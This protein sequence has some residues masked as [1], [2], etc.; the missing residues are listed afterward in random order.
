MQFCHRKGVITSLIINTKPEANCDAMAKKLQ[1]VIQWTKKNISQYN[2]KPNQN[3]ITGHSSRRTSCLAVMNP[4]YGTDPKSI[5]GIILN[6][7]AGLD[8]KLFRR[9]PTKPKMII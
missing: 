9:N 4:K 1:S 3:F 2:V 8:E 6:D 7:A 5:A